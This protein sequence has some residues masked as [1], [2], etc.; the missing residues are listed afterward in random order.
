MI[1]EGDIRW[2]ISIC[3]IEMPLIDVLVGRLEVEVP[4]PIE[5]DRQGHR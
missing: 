4:G 5:M 1:L 3:G 2:R